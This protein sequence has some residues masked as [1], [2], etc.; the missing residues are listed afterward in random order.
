MNRKLAAVSLV[1]AGV[2]FAGAVDARTYKV[3][4]D[5]HNVPEVSFTSKASIVRIVGRTTAID[6]F[7]EIDVNNPSKTKK[8]E[9]VV[10]LTT[11]DTGIALRNEHMVDLIEAKKYPK[12]TFKVKELKAPKLVANEPVEG[13][14]IGEFTLHGVTKPISVPISLHYLPEDKQNPEYRPGDWV[15]FSSN[16]K[17]KLSDY[18]IPLPKPM[19][20][21]KVT[22]D[23]TIQV[24]GMAKG[25]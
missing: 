10:D 22:D 25:I 4:P 24:D 19:F 11:L 2:L 14:A 8:G 15:N 21:V 6:G 3:Q 18:K 5:A 17:I 7:S 23:L 12:A 16:F 9:I 13:T 1:A 20:G